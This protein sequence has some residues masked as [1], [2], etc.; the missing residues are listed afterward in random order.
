ME[1]K[2]KSIEV[3]KYVGITNSTLYRWI[4]VKG[5]PKPYKPRP[6][7]SLWDKKEINRWLEKNEKSL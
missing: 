2:M 4:K 6:N 5:F 1:K 3:L 7:L